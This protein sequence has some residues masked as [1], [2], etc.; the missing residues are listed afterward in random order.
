MN[1]DELKASRN[2]SKR[3]YREKM[4]TLVQGYEAQRSK[5]G[6]DRLRAADP[7]RLKERYRRQEERRQA[8]LLARPDI[9]AIRKSRSAISKTVSALK[10]ENKERKNARSRA[11]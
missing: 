3:R 4:A 8:H 7:A 1:S 2:R 11:R 6:R 9:A 5:R 10:P